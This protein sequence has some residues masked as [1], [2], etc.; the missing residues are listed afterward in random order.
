MRL[1]EALNYSVQI[2]DA[3]TTAHEA[4]I[5]HR[6]LKPSNVMVTEKGVAKVLD[7]GLA[8]LTEVTAPGEDEPTRTIKAA[9]DP[10]TEEGTILGTVSYMS[11][12]QAQGLP[13]DA[14][15]DIFNFGVLLYEMLTGTRAFR[16]DSKMSTLAA[17]IK[18]EPKAVLEVAEGGHC[19]DH[20][21]PRV[22]PLIAARSIAS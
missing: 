11:P 13:V 3:L 8:K 22:M 14:R 2:A 17:I 16:G 4:G 15:T 21:W 5:V 1:N 6:D 18:E 9:S 12:E 10:H 19:L 7:F 20:S